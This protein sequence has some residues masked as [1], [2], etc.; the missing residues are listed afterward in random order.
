[1]PQQYEILSARERGVDAH[2]P[3]FNE[4]LYEH[5]KAT[6]WWLCSI[7]FHVLAMLLLNAFMD[8]GSSQLVV[9]KALE[10]EIAE[11]APELEEEI[12]PEVLETKPIDEQEKV[13]DTPQLE[14]SKVDNETEAEAQEVQENLGDPRFNANSDA[15]FEGPGT[16]A[17]IGIGGGAGGMFG[18][19]KGGKKNLKLEG[20]ANTE[21]ATE[22]G[23]E[24]LKN[25]QSPGGFWDCDNFESMCKKNKCG[26]PGG[27]LFDPGVTGLSLLAFLGYG[28]THKTQRY[29]HVVR[30]GLK[31]LKGIQ[32]AEGCFGA[33]TSNHFTY[34]HA[35]AALAMTEAYGLTQS[36]LF[37]SSAQNGINFVLQCRNPYQA[38][39][40]GVRPQDNDTSVTGWMCMALKSAVGSG[41]DIDPDAFE[42]AK[43]FLDKV[44]EPE[45]GRAGYTARGNGPARPQELMDKFPMDKSESLTAVAILAR[46]FCGATK[47]DEWVKKGA[48][49]LTRLP[50]QWDEAAGTI[51]F[52]YWYY[53]TL[54]MFQVGGD[55]WKKWNEA[56]QTAIIKTQ[57]LDKNDD[58]FG[59]WDAMDPWASDGGRV[60]GVA[61]NVM[62][63]EVYYRYA[64]VFG[65]K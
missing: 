35:I 32:D 14:E 12:K 31:Y 28:E 20:G 39:R 19:R 59:S 21:G 11:A 50:P 51:D 43:T 5:M 33:R 52:Y 26:N 30:N 22:A 2:I 34:N 46:I 29:G 17:S 1:M 18:G 27:P 60:Y 25:H 57:R 7:G 61:V 56:M 42:G 40:Y 53:G 54:A 49:L 48:D 44:T 36:P 9:K 37:K 45:Y 47:D 55:Q 38:W 58:R 65:A 23:L 8:S 24:W 16:N 63:L 4:A 41:L 13:L 64:R 3:D 15:P 10:S 62:C 6:P